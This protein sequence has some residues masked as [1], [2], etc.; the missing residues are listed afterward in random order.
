MKTS[1]TF[2]LSAML[3]SGPAMASNKQIHGNYA[4]NGTTKASVELSGIGGGSLSQAVKGKMK[5]KRGSF[6]IMITTPGWQDRI[7]GT[8]IP[9]SAKLSFNDSL[10]ASNKRIL[11]R[12]CLIGG[13]L[14]AST[15]TGYQNK[16]GRKIEFS[17]LQTFSC[18][19]G[20]GVSYADQFI[21]TCK[22]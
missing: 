5:A 15:G 1:M 18:A 9:E 4:C 10:N 6:D 21:L 11:N 20:S 13:R 7:L 14:F 16:A 3:A 19:N 2:I 8:S 12:D 22:R 17:I